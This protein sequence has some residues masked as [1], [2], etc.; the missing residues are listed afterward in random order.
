MDQDFFGAFPRVAEATSE[1]SFVRLFDGQ[2]FDV[3]LFDGHANR[4]LATCHRPERVAG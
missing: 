2:L 3:R 4:P 1:Y